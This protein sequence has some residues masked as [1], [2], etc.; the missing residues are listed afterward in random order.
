MK[1]IKSSLASCPQHDS[2][3]VVFPISHDN[4][5]SEGSGGV[6]AGTRVI[7]LQGE[8]KQRQT[9]LKQAADR[10]PSLICYHLQC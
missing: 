2:Y 6:H 4:G 8:R 5:R 9:L 7:D 1:K 10:S 3:P